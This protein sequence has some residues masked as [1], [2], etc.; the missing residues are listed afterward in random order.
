MASVCCPSVGGGVR[1]APGVSDNLTGT[2]SAFN[3]P[4]VAVEGNDV[5]LTA[6][7]SVAEAVLGCRLDVPTLDGTKLTVK[8]PPG[9]SSGAR[10]R[11]RG[12]GIKGGDQYIEA[13]VMVP[14][15]RDDKSK[16]LIEEFAR[17]HPQNLR[18]GPPWE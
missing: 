15:P 12:K 4:I 3:G 17:L 7:L 13:K 6:P 5:I 14:A 11:L 18:T 8:I 9:T 16:E 1:M 2:P 10:L